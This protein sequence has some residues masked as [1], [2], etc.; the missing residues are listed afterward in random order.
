MRVWHDDIR[1]PPDESWEW[2]R[3]NDEAIELLLHNDVEEISLDHDLGLHQHDPY[4]PD[5][6]LQAGWD[7]E[8]DGYVLVKW[9]VLNDHVPPLVTIHSWNPV[10]ARR[11]ADLLRDYGHA[12]IVKPFIREGE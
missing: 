11:M 10:G 7:T 6:D 3:T 8:N 1:L 5:A 4:A 9:M 2:A 12:P